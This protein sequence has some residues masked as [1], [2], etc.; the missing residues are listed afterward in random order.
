[1]AGTVMW[2]YDYLSSRIKCNKKKV[3]KVTSGYTATIFYARLFTD[4]DD[5]DGCGL[6]ISSLCP[7][8]VGQGLTKSSHKRHSTQ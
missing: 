4:D 7:K 1:M 2:R 5:I 8:M 3:Q 6:S